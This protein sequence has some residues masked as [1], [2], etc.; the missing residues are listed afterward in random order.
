MDTRKE[1]PE[2]QDR[3]I[4]G[5]AGLGGVWGRIDPEESIKA[6]LVALENGITAIDTAPAY[7]DAEVLAGK[8]F[9]RWKGSLPR[10]STK[11]GRLKSY[12]ATEGY[13][14]YS[15]SGMEKSVLNSLQVL[16]LPV[17]DVLL[18]HDPSAIPPAD[19]EMVIERMLSFKDKGYARRIG[20]GGNSPD[21]FKKY[22]SAEV[23][24]VLMEYNRL[25]ACCVEALDTTLTFCQS[26]GMRFWAASPLRMGL[27]GNCYDAFAESPPPWVS[28]ANL[29]CAGR[30]RK[31]AAQ[32]HIALPVLAHRFLLSL[33]YSFDMVIGAAS[34]PQL[35]DTLAAIKEG[36]L[37]DKLFKEMISNIDQ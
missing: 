26:Q 21:W 25:D 18:L 5:T 30:L 19:A 8:A 27:L 11:V 16:N 13:Y 4:L 37:P 15:A 12:S 7:G 36:P 32:Y 2:H 20:L 35:L 10:V 1:Q 9:R 23:F 29:A 28:A 31:I 33:P 17:L 14:D 3:C 6:I 22:I 34:L 24:D